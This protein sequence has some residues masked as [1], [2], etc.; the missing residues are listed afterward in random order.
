MHALSAVGKGGFFLDI[1]LLILF[2]KM[3]YDFWNVPII[4]IIEVGDRASGDSG[5]AEDEGEMERKFT[6]IHSNPSATVQFRNHLSKIELKDRYPIQTGTTFIFN[7][8]NF[9]WISIF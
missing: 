9:F 8:G 7:S 6:L 3:Q 4:A 2:H 5:R 1:Y